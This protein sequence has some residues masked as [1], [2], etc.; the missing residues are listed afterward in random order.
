MSISANSHS[1]IPLS[2]GQ[3]TAPPKVLP[4]FLEPSKL[5]RTGFFPAYLAGGLL[6]AAVPV[7]NMAVR[8]EQFTTLPG[9]PLEI[10]LNANWDMM[11]MLNVLLA[12]CGACIIYHNEYANNASQKMDTLPIGS[13][14][15]FLGKYGIAVLASAFTILLETVSLAAC[16]LHWFP[17]S[18]FSLP[19][20]IKNMGFELAIF[21]PTIMLMLVIASVCRNMWISLGIGVIF[22]FTVSIFP[23]DN[24]LL[25][26]CPFATPFQMLHIAEAQGWT[27]QYLCATFIETILFGLL[28]WI[29]KKVRRCF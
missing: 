20:L 23:T 5:K 21:L 13:G 3:R 9:R 15:L 26:L 17:A 12:V 6:G 1:V 4:L 14:R 28:E 7:V 29:A 18:A 22:V 27:M 10:L 11:A 8:P 16:I 19:E 25:S 2:E 24:F